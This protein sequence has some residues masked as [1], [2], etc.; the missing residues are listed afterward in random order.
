MNGA[1]GGSQA[2]RSIEEPGEVVHVLR[3][4]P[5]LQP[6][7]Y[8]QYYARMGRPS[9]A[10]RCAEVLRSVSAFAFSAVMHCLVLVLLAEFMVI[11]MPVIEETLVS[12]QL[13]RPAPVPDR[14]RRLSKGPG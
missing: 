8:G 10:D 13:F 7:A 14:S 4:I 9:A 3:G 6:A 5:A 1:A 11:S 12:V 2:W